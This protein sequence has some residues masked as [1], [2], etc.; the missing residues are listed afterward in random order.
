MLRRAWKPI[1]GTTVL[2]GTPAYLYYRSR[3]PTLETFD[4]SLKAT[5]PD[6]KRQ[7]VT[8]SIPLLTKDQIDGRIREHAS[9]KTMPR[10][11]GIV[12]KSTTAYFASNDPIEDANGSL[13]IERDA[14]DASPPG[15]YL[16][17]AVM[18]GHGGPHTSRV[19]AD[20]LIPTVAM[21]L[22]SRV[23][24]PKA[25]LNDSGLIHK[26]KSLIWSPPNVPY[27]AN[28]ANVSSAIEAAFTKLDAQIVNTPLEI[29][30]NAVDQEALKKRQIPDLSKHPF[31][32]SSI[33]TAMSGSCAL[34]AM[35]D[36]SHRNLYVACLGDSRAV[37]G[38]YEETADG[39]GVWRVEVLTED[40]TGRN[41][42]ELKRIQSEHPA[43]EAQYVVRNG[44][45][46]GGLEPSRA[47]GDARYKWPR[48]VQEV[49][50]KAFMEPLGEAMRTPPPTLKTPPYVI[51][52]PVVT[53]RPLSFLPLPAPD[54]PAPKSA[55]RFLVLAT[56][57]LW[58]ELSNEEVV[59]LV[60]GHFA[61]LRGTIP[62]SALP[63]L[64]PT[65]T[66]TAGVEG[67]DKSRRQQQQGAWAFEDDNLSAHLIRNALG[68][69]DVEHLRKLASIPAP[70]SRRFRDDITV[71]VVWWEDGREGQA[72]VDE[73]AVPKAKL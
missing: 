8:Q 67:K 72:Q 14:S 40:Q 43:D 21:E 53:H 24:D 20:I 34:L 41:P 56:D 27:D 44:R 49:L 69:G 47:F 7:M 38:V 2:V 70:Y 6:G 59:A 61:G 45:I 55:L 52:K 22:A 18:D 10:P 58:D 17:F 11:G 15:D 30:Y 16:F 64:V 50:N 62:K 33:Q 60:G 35:L 57:G 1:L 28:P 29:L 26:A 13:L 12:W 31:A 3:K 46:L 25:N 51:A 42:N 66:G 19:L 65:S 37:A 73:V 54:T 4:I 63:D 48:E 23:N 32:L 71:T 68:G 9:A 5:G 36:T 39:K